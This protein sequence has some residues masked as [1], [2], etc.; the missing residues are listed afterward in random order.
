MKTK[1]TVA[2]VFIVIFLTILTLVVLYPIVYVIAS[3]VTPGRSMAHMPIIPFSDGVTLDHFRHLFQN[4]H[5]P[6]WFRNT[7]VVAAATSFGTMV[8]ASIGAYAFSRF[9]FAMK[10]GIM[11]TM[12]ALQVFP[13]ILGM[14]AIFI[15]LWRFNLLDNIW[16]LV[17]LYLAG[18]MPF[19]IWMM[20]SYMDTIPKSLDEAARIDGASNFRTFLTIIMPTAKPMITFMMLTT[21]TMPWMDYILPTI[22]LRS[23][24]NQTLA[25][26]LFS[27]V[28]D[29]SNNFTWFAA[30]SVLI[31]IPFVIFFILGQKMLVTSFG[32]GA[33]KE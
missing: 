26:G 32:A 29:R 7:F 2:N 18:N 19:N 9:R 27:F 22:I 30:G 1:Q 20:K 3:S 15:I 14:T 5:Y 25:I 23:P 31:T 10:K 16:G 8:I 33:V 21:F 12:L 17:L 13:A 4:T 24:E 6:I 28:T 11:L